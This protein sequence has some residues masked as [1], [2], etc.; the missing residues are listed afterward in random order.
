MG[1][2]GDVEERG[3]GWGKGREYMVVNECVLLVHTCSA[4]WINVCV[5]AVCGF[6]RCVFLSASVGY[7]ASDG[8]DVLEQWSE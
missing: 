1:G 8:G 7:S 3:V 6:G 4:A 5:I 2:E